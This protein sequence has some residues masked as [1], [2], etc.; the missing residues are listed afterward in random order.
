MSRQL[1]ISK[2]ELKVPNIVDDIEKG[3]IV[4]PDFQRD[5]VWKTTDTAK[6]LES[7][8]NGYYINTILTL[9]VAI[10]SRGPPFPI[11]YVEGVSTPPNLPFD[12]QM[13]LD[14]Q[15]R[16]TSIYYALVAPEI[17]LSN[18]VYPQIFCLSFQKAVEGELDEDSV[19]WRRADWE[20]SQR[21]VQNDYKLQL[22]ED[23]IPFTIF[24]D[25]DSFR[26]WRR[27]IE[28]F[29]TTSELVTISDINAFEDHTETFRN[30]SIPVIQMAADT[31]ED[32]VVQTFERI[33]TQGLDLDVFDILT[34]RLWIKNIKLRELWEVSLHH[35]QHMKNY[36]TE[37]SESGL[38]TIMLKTLALY[39]DGECKEK[40]LRELSHEHFE[41]DWDTTSQIVSR[42]I[43]RSISS[44]V[45]GFG[46]T[47]KFGFPYTS[48]L[49]TL[50][51][52]LYLAEQTS[53]YPR[54]DALEKI[55]TWYWISIF[56]RRYSSS[57]DSMLLRDLREVKTWMI[58]SS[59]TLPD[60]IQRAPQTIPAEVELD[61]ITRGGLYTGV[62]CLLILNQIR[63]FNTFEGVSLHD[64]DDHHIFPKAK[65][66]EGIN[67][68]KIEDRIRQD[69]ILNRTIIE[70][71]NNRFKIKDNLPGTYIRDMIDEHD[72]GELGV[73]ELLKAHF[74]NEQ[75]FEALLENE[76]QV[77]CDTRK[78]MIQEEISRRTGIQIDW[79]KQSEFY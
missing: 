19:H 78:E 56:S 2:S 71:G 32:K 5:F 8:L 7:M 38:R 6:L 54:R 55:Q 63:D 60:A 26:N 10:G 79:S 59:N 58:K 70:K 23:L 52:L 67:G 46:V 16:L 35:Y 76:Y 44:A 22:E 14:G 40:N 65:L 48:L 11:R 49:P 24:K 12:I 29:S 64:I 1:K 36:S 33:N 57:S 18:T 75:A 3:N 62:M 13:I 9:P 41:A 74:I 27:G 42:A 50:A 17:S 53:S 28:T 43:E 25:L 45:G 72:E 30:Y 68:E 51:N 69:T 37:F 66:K 4:L 21:L 77:F 39:R 73:R 34:A 15:Q 31:P 47:V 61:R 20:S